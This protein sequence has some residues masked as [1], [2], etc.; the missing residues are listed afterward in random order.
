MVGDENFTEGRDYR[1]QDGIFKLIGVND[2][3]LLFTSTRPNGSRLPIA[4]VKKQ[5]GAVMKRLAIEEKCT[6]RGGKCDKAGCGNC[7]PENFE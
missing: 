3:I 7:H 6:A 2:S 4:T 5:V 1:I